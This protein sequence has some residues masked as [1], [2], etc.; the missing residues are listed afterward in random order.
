[1]REKRKILVT[2]IGGDVANGILKVLEQCD[3]EVYGCDI[4]D[5]PVGMDRVKLYW[6]SL[7]AVD[8]DYISDLI[9]KC[10][11]YGITHLIPV[12]EKEIEVIGK[13]M[14]IFLDSRIKVLLNSENIIENFLDKKNTYDLLSKIEGINV[15][16]TMLPEEFNED[17]NKYI[18]KPRKSCGSKYI[19]IISTNEE[20]K[21]IDTEDCVV[22]EYIDNSEEEYTV[23]VFSNGN[24]TDTIIFKRKLQHGYTSFVELMEDE[25]I[26]EDAKKIAKSINLRGYINL[27]LRKNNKSNYIFEINPRISGT[28]YFRDMLGF[29]DVLW[30]LDLLDG[31][32]EYTY[33]QKYKKAIGMRELREK[34]VVLE[35]NMKR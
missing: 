34:Y 13:N 14:N 25:S 33:K 29:R 2:A 4:N 31:N 23:G 17:G 1:M 28:V 3:D 15:P 19:N 12:N 30:W 8:K 22:Q 26:V 6:K 20:L 32:E 24:S 11:A 18:V 9:K 5:Y 10:K 16:K 35:K 21:E 27:Q 7:L